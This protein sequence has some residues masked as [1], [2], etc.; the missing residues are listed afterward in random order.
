MVQRAV[1]RQ[2]CRVCGRRT[3][4][5]AEMD[6][7]ISEFHSGDEDPVVWLSRAKDQREFRPCLGTTPWGKELR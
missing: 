4:S 1:V 7:H 6:E 2:V 5:K 3:T